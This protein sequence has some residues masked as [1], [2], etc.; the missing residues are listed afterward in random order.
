[1]NDPTP[2]FCFHLQL[3]AA[4]VRMIGVGVEELGVE[5]FVAGKF[6]DGGELSKHRYNSIIISFIQ[7]L[8]DIHSILS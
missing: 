3:D 1:M 4:N 8:I 2:S 6:F 5:E 7:S